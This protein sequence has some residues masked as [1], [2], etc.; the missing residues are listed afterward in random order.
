MSK[1]NARI[2]EREALDAMLPALESVPE[3]L[4]DQAKRVFDR[5]NWLCRAEKCEKD[6]ARL[7]ADRMACAQ[8]RIDALAAGV[9]RCPIRTAQPG[10]IT[11]RE[12]L[13][14]LKAQVEA[15]PVKWADQEEARLVADLSV[16]DKELAV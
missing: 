4:A 16:I 12:H 8:E 11:L 5:H 6:I 3:T 10:N 1:L 9:Q 13:A 2:K 14:A 15:D 7:R